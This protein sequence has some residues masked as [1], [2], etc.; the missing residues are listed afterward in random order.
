VTHIFKTIDGPNHHDGTMSN[1]DTDAQTESQSELPIFPTTAPP[2]LAD[3]D[4]TIALFEPVLDRLADMV[5]IPDQQLTWPTPCQGFN[6][7][8]LRNHVLGWLSFFAAALSDPTAAQQRPDA[9]SWKLAEGHEPAGVVERASAAI[10]SAVRDGVAS[11]LV[12]MSQA[13]MAGDGVL[14]MA[15]GEYLVH[16]WDLATA[17]GRRWTEPGDGDWSQAAE[18]ALAFLHTTV[19]PEYRGEDSGFF[20]DEVTAADD[21]STFERLLCFAGRDPGWTSGSAT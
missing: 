6:V 12:T 9:D 4:T 1:T 8:Q 19:A 5:E 11:E 10:T 16:G 13:R 18:P 14:A 17:T 15:L 21:A 3:V 20:G 2:E 7:D